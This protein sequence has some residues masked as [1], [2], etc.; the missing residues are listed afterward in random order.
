M[1]AVA[2]TAGPVPTRPG[3]I[4]LLGAAALLLAG[5]MSV[6]AGVHGA[7]KTP[8]ASPSFVPCRKRQQPHSRVDWNPTERPTRTFFMTGKTV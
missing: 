1:A 4:R 8:A 7:D 3:R 2:D 6:A 5:A